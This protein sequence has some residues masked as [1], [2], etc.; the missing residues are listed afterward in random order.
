MA[1]IDA[2]FEQL[3]AAHGSDLHLGEGEPPKIRIHG[4]ISAIREQVLTHDE[5]QQLLKEIAG[6]KRWKNLKTAAISILPMK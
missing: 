5:M 4:E 2:F 6:D 1:K 3:I